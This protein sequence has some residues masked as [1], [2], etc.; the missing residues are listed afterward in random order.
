MW[1][2]PFDVIGTDALVPYYSELEGLKPHECD[3]PYCGMPYLLPMLT[4]MRYVHERGGILGVL[5][6]SE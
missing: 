2:I 1:F 5:G 4:M 3:G 6:A